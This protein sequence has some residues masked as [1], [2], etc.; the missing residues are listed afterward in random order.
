M[1]STNIRTQKHREERN[2]KTKHE[3]QKNQHAQIE[4]ERISLI[5]IHHPHPQ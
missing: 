1:I 2:K 3:N 5:I 4:R